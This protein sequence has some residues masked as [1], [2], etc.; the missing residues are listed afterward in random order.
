MSSSS[1]WPLQV[2]KFG[3][4]TTRSI[5]S[6]Y[7]LNL[8]ALEIKI[9]IIYINFIIS[10]DFL[11]LLSL[12]S[13]SR[14]GFR[15]AYLIPVA[16]LNLLRSILPPLLA[17]I[18]RIRSRGDCESLSFTDLPPTFSPQEVRFDRKQY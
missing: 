13:M 17:N 7:P 15:S 4:Y 10:P 18:L 16:A 1:L 12:A 5:F 8:A 14:I 11:I 2:L 3:L 6:L 9:I